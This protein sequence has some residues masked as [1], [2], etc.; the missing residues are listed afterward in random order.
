MY[1][2]SIL[3]QLTIISSLGEESLSPHLDATPILFADDTSILITDKN[4]DNLVSK[5]N[6]AFK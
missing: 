4:T 3:S 1:L 2:Y 6:A 5:L